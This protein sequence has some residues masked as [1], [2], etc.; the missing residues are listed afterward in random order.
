M[1]KTDDLY[2]LHDYEALIG[3][4]RTLPKQIRARN[5]FHSNPMMGL[6]ISAVRGLYIQLASKLN[7]G[8]SFLLIK[9]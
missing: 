8:L 1:R 7:E 3:G 9:I 4:I 6:R 5:N 2:A